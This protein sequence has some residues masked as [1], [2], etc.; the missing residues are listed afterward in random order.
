MSKKDLIVTILCI[1]ASII[2]GI[3]SQDLLV[4]GVILATGLLCAYFASEGKRINYILGVINYVLMGY[5]SL[6]NNLFGLFFFYIFVFAP[7]Q[8]SGFIS[9][10]KNLDA[11]GSVKV[12]HFEIRS[13]IIV[14]VS[15]II[16]S[17]L[18]GYLLTLIPDQQIAFLD[19]TSNCINLC[20]VVLMILRF[21][22][23]WWLWLVN[24]I[25][26]LVIWIIMTAQGG[27]GSIMMLLVSIGY[28]LINI[29]GIIQWN[30]KRHQSV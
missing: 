4:G 15:C 20:G 17:L 5:V 3:I 11:G 8:I 30:R 21:E 1:A 13:S 14:V 2:C 26:D 23:S 7:L 19:S 25:V 22:E 16:G 24:N 28:L 9:W 27:A 10:K 12:R 29:Y 18:L 6:K